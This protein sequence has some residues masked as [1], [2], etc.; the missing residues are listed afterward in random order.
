MN[1][2]VKVTSFVPIIN[3]LTA[4]MLILLNCFIGDFVIVLGI[5]G[6]SGS[7]KTTFA[8]KI[9]NLTNKKITTIHMDSY[10]LSPLPETLINNG[11]KGNFDHPEAIDWELLIDHII[12]LKAAQTIQSPIYDFNTSSRLTETNTIQPSEVLLVEGIFG[13]FS[14]EV[15]NLFNLKVFLHVEADIRFTRR[16]ERDTTER[17][18]SVDSIIQQYY[19]SVR[20]MHNKYVEP[21]KQ[22]ADITVGEETEKAANVIRSFLDFSEEERDGQYLS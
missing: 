12:K 5:A 7:G 6:G 15:R 18:R 19:K 1:S 16:L 10:Y 9:A 14:K 21:Q 17:G 11:D 8:N 4:N 2:I 22:F 3:N 20:P 13:L